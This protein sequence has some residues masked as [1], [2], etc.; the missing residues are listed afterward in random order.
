MLAAVHGQS[1]NA[2]HLGAS[3][4][5]DHKTVLRHHDFSEGA[6]LIRRLPPYVVNIRKRLV[7]TPRAFWRDSGLLHAVLNVT[8]LT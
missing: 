6:F 4:A 5:L 1:L 3:L 2:S 7:R 8:D